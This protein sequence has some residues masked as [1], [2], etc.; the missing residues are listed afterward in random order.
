MAAGKAVVTSDIGGFREVVRHEETG[1]QTWANNAGS[2]GWGIKRVLGDAALAA[3]LRRNGQREAAARFGWAGIA[4]ETVTVY[5]EVLGLAEA[6]Q[7][8]AAP[9]AG[10]G[11]RPR[12]L[13]LS[14][15]AR[16]S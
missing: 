11:I 13:A 14:E 16:R 12:Y 2:L 15:A 9:E 3:R 7:R 6:G 5:E 10:P 1:L 8:P 4:E